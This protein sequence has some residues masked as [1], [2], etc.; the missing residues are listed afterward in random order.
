MNKIILLGRLTKAPEIR[1]TQSNNNKVALFTLA[2][3]RKYVKQ[4]EERQADF[5]NIVAY[6]RLAE[7]AEKYLHQG[8]QI[9]ISGRLQNRNYEDKNGV[10][11]YV[12]E[13]IAEEVYFA[14]SQKKADESILYSNN[15]VNTN[16][17]QVENTKVSE[18][19]NLDSD[20]LPF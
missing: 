3:N 14:D 4:G 12:T 16:D 11:R 17:S 8:L 18:E 10:T 15:S 6:S 19:F 2:V 7:L 13:V 20:D 5:F 1:F 9:C